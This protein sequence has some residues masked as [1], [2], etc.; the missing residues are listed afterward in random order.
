M[1]DAAAAAETARI[2]NPFWEQVTMLAISTALTTLL[3]TAAWLMWSMNSKLVV[4]ET[5][6]ESIRS[7]IVT[8]IA[9][10]DN[11]DERWHASDARIGGL[12]TRVAVLESRADESDF[13]RSPYRPTP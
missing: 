11:H 1:P 13:H 3:G 7:T 6:V 9:R 5:S 12:E 8:A 2:L 4:L 10:L